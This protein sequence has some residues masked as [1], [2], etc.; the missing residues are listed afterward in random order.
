M[1]LDSLTFL[2]LTRLYTFSTTG[3][4][5][6]YFIKVDGDLIPVDSLPKVNLTDLQTLLTFKSPHG[7]AY[8]VMDSNE[9]VYNYRNKFSVL[10]KTKVAAQSYTH[11]A[12]S[13]LSAWKLTHSGKLPPFIIRR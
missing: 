8:K 12:A 3:W 7:H 11:I 4:K 5:V 9:L 10:F 6:V 1:H 13:I 2:I